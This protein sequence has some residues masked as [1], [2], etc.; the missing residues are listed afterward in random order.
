[1]L[2]MLRFVRSLSTPAVLFGRIFL[3][4]TSQGQCFAATCVAGFAGALRAALAECCIIRVTI[5]TC[6]YLWLLINPSSI[7]LTIRSIYTV[8]FATVPWQNVM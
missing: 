1:M 8:G 2:Q 3:L 7:N 5:L 6:F 4:F